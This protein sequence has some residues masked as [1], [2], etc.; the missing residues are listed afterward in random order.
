MNG[1]SFRIEAKTVIRTPACVFLIWPHRVA[2]ACNV[3]A[4]AGQVKPGS[5]GM[6]GPKVKNS[7]N[8]HRQDIEI[9]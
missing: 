1:P 5:G 7:L 3:K 2:C 9:Q 4:G 6:H 8:R